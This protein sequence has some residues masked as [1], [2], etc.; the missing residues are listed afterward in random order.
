MITLKGDK[1]GDRQRQMAKALGGGPSRVPDHKKGSAAERFRKEQMARSG[2]SEVVMI[3]GKTEARR[4][5]DEEGASDSSD[6]DSDF[7]DDDDAA[8]A[9]LREKRMQ[10]IKKKAGRDIEFRAMGHGKYSLVSED[11][12]LPAVTASK[13]VVCHFFHKDFQKCL[14][15]DKHLALLAEKYLPTRFI[16]VDSE[17]TPFFVGKLKVRVLPTLCLFKDGVCV[18]R[19]TGFEGLG[20]DGQDF[21]T[22]SLEKR[23]ANSGVIVMLEELIQKRRDEFTNSIRRGDKAGGYDSDEDYD[24][25]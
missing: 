4:Q 2:E 17:K 15:M 14:V 9:A 7:D 20:G 5:K 16:R 1:G 19:V 6:L 10:A 24:D 22:K 11:D 12:F 3:R 8:F 18:D 23:I 13:Y 25:A 21:T